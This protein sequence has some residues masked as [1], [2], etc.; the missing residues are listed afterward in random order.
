MLANPVLVLSRSLIR[1]YTAGIGS[2]DEE[3]LEGRLGAGLGGQEH[4]Q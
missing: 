2:V 3:D 4:W 1:R